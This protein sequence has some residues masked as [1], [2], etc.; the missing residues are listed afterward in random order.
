MDL[1]SLT[2]DQTLRGILHGLGPDDLRYFIYKPKHL[3]ESSYNAEVYGETVWFPQ[4]VFYFQMG[5]YDRDATKL[6]RLPPKDQAT[7]LVALMGGRD[8]VLASSKESLAKNEYAWAAQLV[9]YLY[10]LDPNDAG[11]R[12]VKADALRK[13]GQLSMGSIGRSFLISEARVLEGKEQ[14]PRNV[15]PGAAS[16][17]ADP[18]TFVNLFR[19]RIDPQK[20]ES[21]DTVVT[22]TFTGQGGKTVGLHVR[23]GVAEFLDDPA[24]HYRKPDIALTMDGATWAS[25]YLSGTG[26]KAA[27]D[28]GKVKVTAGDA[29]QA[30]AIFDF[31]DK[32]QPARNVTI[33]ALHD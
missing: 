7:R 32:F 31:F 28:A 19:V 21:T 4:A 16:I 26:L 30:A 33:P 24:K 5:W 20:A 23:K 2:Y 18:A 22:L 25:L 9:N 12:Q 10:T 13:L 17:A 14:I 1:N 8:K 11:V 3:A 29:A 6:Y 27:V 15:P